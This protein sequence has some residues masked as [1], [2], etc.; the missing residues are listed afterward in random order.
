MTRAKATLSAGGTTARVSERVLRQVPAPLF[1]PTWRPFSHGD[2]LDSLAVACKEMNLSVTRKEYSMTKSGSRFFGVWELKEK[3]NKEAIC[4]VGFRGA[5]DKHFAHGLCVGER[6][7][8]CDNL[9]FDSSFVLFR[10]H[11]GQLTKEELVFIAM[12]A[13]KTALPRYD[14]L[15]RWHR[16]LR[17]TKLTDQEA[18]LLMVAAMRKELIPPLNYPRAHEL[19]FGKDTKYTP[20]LHG[21]HGT[22]TELYKDQSLLGIQYKNAELN[23][24]IQHEA[25]RLIASP[26]TARIAFETIS[27]KAVEAFDKDAAE[28]AGLIQAS[29]G[30]FRQKVKE[31]KSEEKKKAAPKKAAS[32]KKATK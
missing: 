4:A 3:Q 25:P 20:T 30:L 27:A 17:A 7:F 2:M 22:V 6:V 5:I 11:T 8:V 31:W 15:R 1:T 10:K 18:S 9:V 32:K 23:Q 19:Y 16:S 14:D 12:E 21:F 13:L 29:A 24:F 28:K 26:S